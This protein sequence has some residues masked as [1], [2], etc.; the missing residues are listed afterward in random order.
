MTIVR[1]QLG[2]GGVAFTVELADGE[3]ILLIGDN[4]D[5][6]TLSVTDPELTALVDKIVEY[7]TENY[8]G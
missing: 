2:D 6:K 8:D 4:D 7:I 5:A 1:L 3:E